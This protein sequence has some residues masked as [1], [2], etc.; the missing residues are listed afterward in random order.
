MDGLARRPR[1]S[2]AT[3]LEL[4]RA[5]QAGDTAARQELIEAFL[6]AIGALARQYRSSVVDRLD[7]LQEGVVDLLRA[8]HRYDPDRGTAFCRTRSGG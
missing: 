4:V 1:L 2:A 6:P 7:L 3:E 5:A 8:L